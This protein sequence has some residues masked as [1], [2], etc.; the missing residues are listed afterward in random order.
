MILEK[1]KETI[2]EKGFT[3]VFDMLPNWLRWILVLPVSFVTMNLVSFLV[4]FFWR[5]GFR[6]E[7]THTILGAIIF[8]IIAILSTLWAIH[9]VVP[10]YKV[11][12][13]IVCASATVLYGMFS[14]YA[15]I[16]MARE[17]QHA[18]VAPFHFAVITEI[19]TAGYMIVLVL[20]HQKRV[21]TGR[22]N[23]YL[24]T[25]RETKKFLHVLFYILVVLGVI[26][27]MWTVLVLWN[28]YAL[29]GGIIG[30]I[31]PIF[32]EIFVG[33][34]TWR[35]VGMFDTSYNSLLCLYFCMWIFY[36]VIRKIL[37][38]LC[39]MEMR[40]KLGEMI[41]NYSGEKL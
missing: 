9:E 10:K 33:I 5:L 2:H 25:L 24:D 4:G 37:N 13:S 6:E 35:S 14:S 39:V 32:S 12:I 18:G 34:G 28:S 31:T 19:L 20:L 1:T 15:T 23:L 41:K 8:E 27:H 26:F 17:Y 16:P 40:K 22:T 21:Q 38:M 29:L 11:E 7:L 36:I 3:R 30:L